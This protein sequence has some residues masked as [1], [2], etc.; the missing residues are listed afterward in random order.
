M[1]R[2]AL[3]LVTIIMLRAIAYAGSPPGLQLT[4]PL[5]RR[6]LIAPIVGGTLLALAG[7]LSLA[8][9]ACAIAT[10]RSASC[11]R[12]AAWVPSRCPA[13]RESA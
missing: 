12:L 1:T 3:V 10:E 9:I 11:S 4:P 8:G 6:Y 13:E 7:A 5:S 2:I